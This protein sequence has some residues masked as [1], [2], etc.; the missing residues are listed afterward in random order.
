MRSLITLSV[1]SCSMAFCEEAK[2]ATLHNFYIGSEI[3]N[4][5]V[6]AANS[7]SNKLYPGIHCSYQYLN[8]WFFGTDLQLSGK[9]ADQA[10]SILLDIE[11]QVGYCFPVLEGKAKVVPFL[12]LSWHYDEFFHNILTSTSTHWVDHT[13][14]FKSVY[15]I[16]NFFSIGLNCK[17]IIGFLGQEETTGPNHRDNMKF[18]P[19]STFGYEI[20]LPIEFVVPYLHEM[21]YNI[22][23]T[24]HKHDVSGD[25]YRFGLKILAGFKF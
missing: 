25:N 10:Y 5:H 1:L 2:P 7:T 15:P 20:A 6:E 4:H 12:G 11:Q 17:G 14:G 18:K 24:F 23:P 3:Y 22:Q 16:N 19:D 21:Y 8:S 13:F 9:D